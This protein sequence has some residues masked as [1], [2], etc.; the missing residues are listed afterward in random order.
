[1]TPKSAEVLVSTSTG[2]CSDVTVLG[3]FIYCQYA[4]LLHVYA[5]ILFVDF[6]SAL[7]AFIAAFLQDTL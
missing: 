1:M 7:N 4:P 5:R 2:W 3:M 6:G